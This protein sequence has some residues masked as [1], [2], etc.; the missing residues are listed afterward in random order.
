MS[1]VAWTGIILV[2]LIVMVSDAINP[3]LMHCGSPVDLRW[4]LPLI[5]AAIVMIIEACL[6]IYHRSIVEPFHLWSTIT[7]ALY[8]VVTSILYGLTIKY[9]WVLSLAASK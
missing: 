8:L 3:Q 7:V 4:L 6:V 2:S 1:C 9:Q 5:A